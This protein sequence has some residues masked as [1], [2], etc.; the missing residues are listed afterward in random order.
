MIKK[1]GKAFLVLIITAIII[2]FLF[3]QKKYPLTIVTHSFTIGDSVD[4]LN[5]VIVYNNGAVYSKSYGKHYSKDSVYYYGKKWQCVEY[6]KRYYF[7]YLKHKMPNGFG[8]ANAFFDKKLAQGA[9]N[10]SR[11]LYQY[12]NGSNEPP[13]I[14]DLLI[15]DGKYGHVAIVSE[16]KEDEIEIVQQNIFM[17]PRQTLP[18]KHS[19]TNYSIG[20]KRKPLGWLRLKQ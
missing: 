4:S 5:G 1:I 20:E 11:G 10:K 8:N 19:N 14:N 15:F 16:V 6:V 9:F 3:F 13:K 2:Y 18:L 17:T 12:I 7:D